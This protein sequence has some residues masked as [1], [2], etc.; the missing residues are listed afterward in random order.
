MV[1]VEVVGAVETGVAV[2][3]EVAEVVVVL[4][5][6]FSF[7]LRLQ[8]KSVLGSSAWLLLIISQLFIV[9]FQSLKHKTNA[10]KEGK[11][12]AQVVTTEQGSR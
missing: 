3:V 9:R 7:C 11:H 10:W 6:G 4:S 5:A 1:E 12:R 8:W 2:V